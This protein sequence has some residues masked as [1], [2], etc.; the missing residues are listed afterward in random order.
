LRL[1]LFRRGTGDSVEREVDDLGAV[2]LFSFVDAGSEFGAGQLVA[3]QGRGLAQQGGV[4][5]VGRCAGRG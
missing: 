4:R 3:Q 5:A 1:C 2:E